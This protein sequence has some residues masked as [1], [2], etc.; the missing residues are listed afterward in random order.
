[1]IVWNVLFLAGFITVTAGFYR[2][3]KSDVPL[4][5]VLWLFISCICA[6]CFHA[7]AGA[8][9]HRI[10]I[11]ISVLSVGI[12]DLACGSFLLYS[13]RHGYQK[14]K[15]SYG[16]LAM[17]LLLL[18]L[19]GGIGYARFGA[20]LAFRY[21]SVDGITHYYEAVRVMQTGKI[22]AMYFTALND[23]FLA[24]L[25]KPFTSLLEM[26]RIEPV[27]DLIYLYLTAALMYGIAREK[28]GNLF[29]IIGCS[30]LGIVYCLGYPLNNL[31]SGFL[32]LS[33]GVT[34]SALLVVVSDLY[35]Q[36]VLHERAAFLFLMLGALGLIT[37][38]ALFSPPV[39]CMMAFA[40]GRKKWK[41]GAS[42]LQW[43]GSFTAVFAIPCIVGMAYTYAGIF[44]DG[45][46]VS[47]AIGLEGYIYRNNWSD[48]IPILPFA[49]YG[50]LENRKRKKQTALLALTAVEA[51]F[52]ALM[53]F[54]QFQGIVSA[55][56][57][58]KNNFLM[59]LILFLLSMDALSG[60]SD[61]EC[62]GIRKLACIYGAVWCVCVGLALGGLN[63][64]MG[65]EGEEIFYGDREG[66]DFCKVFWHNKELI[67][68][69]EANE[70]KTAPSAERQKL[71]EL[72]ADKCRTEN[73]SV[74]PVGRS[75][76]RYFINALT[77][78]WNV[79]YLHIDSPEDY[80][81]LL[82]EWQPDYI[83]VMKKSSAYRKNKKY[84]RQFPKLYENEEGFFARYKKVERE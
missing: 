65:R 59:W 33:V 28:A 12:A 74:F 36:G 6:L 3:K 38:Y 56:Y 80:V 31:I 82:E 5:G 53:L 49:I 1:M 25:Y 48:F 7:L 81:A 17:L 16:D 52:M 22:E 58:Y 79:A 75:G 47:G 63:Q 62:A 10:S 60:I 64:V 11:P 23:S 37:C 35:A 18:C 27:A 50:F 54:L 71:Y 19:I 24:A 29:C 69:I 67:S 77:G 66:I 78:Q 14:Y 55:Y 9:F 45:L 26:Y 73:C 83:C 39:Y 61:G 30:F 76:D 70:E 20:D 15:W 42:L 34:I 41:E 84:L 21:R 68:G 8:L 4:G 44:K 57:Y 43:L 72:S 51:L 13:H 46:T 2:M 40:L 32:Y